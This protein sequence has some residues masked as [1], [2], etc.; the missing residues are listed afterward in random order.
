MD[1]EH[2]YY[3]ILGVSRTASDA[4]IR[5]AFRTLA[6]EHHP[7]S[8]K[9]G[10]KSGADARDFRLISEAYETLKDANRRAAY[11]RE[12]YEARQLETPPL[13]PGKR[14]FTAGIAVG[15]VLA[16]IAAAAVNSISHALRAD[17]GKAQDSL[18][19]ALSSASVR[20]AGGVVSPGGTEAQSAEAEAVPSPPE[21]EKTLPSL[22]PS[23]ASAG[24]PS[25][26]EASPKPQAVGETASM[27]AE[28]G[29]KPDEKN[30]EPVI[31][32]PGE[33]I[34]FS[35]GP[36]AHKKIVRLVPGKGLAHGF[37]DCRSCPEMM[38][39]PGGEALMGTRAE[40]ASAHKEETP[41]HRIR[42]ANP[43][44]ISKA[45]ISAGN[46]QACVDAGVCRLNLSSLLAS[47]PRVP[48]TR[49]SWFDAHTY[50]GWLSQTTGWHYRLLTEAEWEY[51]VRAG[52]GRGPM[53]PEAGRRYATGLMKDTRGFFPRVRFGHFT[54]A[55]PNA[56]GLQ[57]GGVLEWVE[58]CWHRTYDHAPEDASPWLTGGDCTYR[59]VRGNADAA[60]GLGWRPS[61]RSKEFAETKSPT[62]G[63]RVAREIPAPAKTALEG[64]ASARRQ[65]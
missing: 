49:M 32:A 30:V 46:W 6:K 41:A 34:E 37:S 3:A 43:L 12:I 13:R 65:P 35:A 10:G 54:T 52:Q 57:G 31:F 29:G 2:D 59:V 20:D 16:L 23:Q 60:G 48:A 36:S 62:L 8:R 7:D 39:I 63:F 42:L 25:L 22:A 47:G 50:A 9:A 64:I 24:E 45:V 53:E 61:A 51:A 21:A 28:A 33:P 1:S 27:S 44:A 40:G 55:G 56:W 17:G 4:E 38:V 11:D 19:P 58:D 15:I 26:P 18:T 14:S 5:R